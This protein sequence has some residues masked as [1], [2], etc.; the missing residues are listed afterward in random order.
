MPCNY[1]EAVELRIHSQQQPQVRG[2]QNLSNEGTERGGGSTQELGTHPS[3]RLPNSGTDLSWKVRVVCGPWPEDYGEAKDMLLQVRR[4][5]LYSPP[6]SSNWL[7][8]GGQC[9]DF[10]NL[11]AGANEA[12]CLPR[13]KLPPKT[14]R[15][16]LFLEPQ[17][18]PCHQVGVSEPICSFSAALCLSG[19]F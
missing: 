2:R 15:L 11:R 7:F 16:P 18:D 1:L 8:R 6:V 9:R 3:L 10:Q 12:S 17:G 5:I 19:K 13:K 14:S 4:L